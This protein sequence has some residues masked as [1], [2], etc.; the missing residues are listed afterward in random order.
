MGYHR[1]EPNRTPQPISTATAMNPAAAAMYC[2]ARSATT[3]PE[4]R[5]FTAFRMRNSGHA[6]SSS[7]AVRA[8]AV[9]FPLSAFPAPIT[10]LPKMNAINNERPTSRQSGRCFNP[11][12]RC[13]FSHSRKPFPVIGCRTISLHSGHTKRVVWAAM[14]RILRSPSAGRGRAGTGLADSEQTSRV[15]VQ[16]FS[17]RCVIRG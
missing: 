5:Y 2:L 1:K 8:A 13:P 17:K 10:K 4:R 16:H 7:T 12:T 6:V 11:C 3:P 14:E 15:V 9:A